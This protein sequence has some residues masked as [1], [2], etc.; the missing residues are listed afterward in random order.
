MPISHPKVFCGYSDITAIHGLLNQTG[1]GLVTFHTPMPSRLMVGR[2]WP[3]VR[4][5]TRGMFFSR[6]TGSTT[7]RIGD[8]RGIA[9][10]MV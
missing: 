9:R 10:R 2:V 7:S 6:Q 1:E 5:V 4:P 8:H 3:Q